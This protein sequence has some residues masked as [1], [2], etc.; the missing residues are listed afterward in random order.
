MASSSPENLVPAVTCEA[1]DTQS[2][3]YQEGLNLA[4]KTLTLLDAANILLSLGKDYEENLLTAL[5]QY[6]AFQAIHR[7][8]MKSALKFRDSLSNKLTNGH[9]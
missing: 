1:T 8:A 4:D 5:E 9:Q 2:S 3:N 6:E 7:L